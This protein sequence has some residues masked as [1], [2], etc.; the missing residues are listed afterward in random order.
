MPRADHLPVGRSLC[1][2]VCVCVF[3]CC[4]CCR[5]WFQ[6]SKIRPR[7]APTRAFGSRVISRDFDV[8]A[9]DFTKKVLHYSWHPSENIIAVAGLN[10][11]YIFAAL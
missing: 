7:P 6:L 3:A 2:S 5:R 10:N 4:C 8:D 9:L 1:S 11:L